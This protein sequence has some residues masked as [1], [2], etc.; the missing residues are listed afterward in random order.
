MP[1]ERTGRSAPGSAGRTPRPRAGG[2][3]TVRCL[4]PGERAGTS[5]TTLLD[6]RAGE[7]VRV[8]GISRARHGAQRRRLLDL[9]VVRGT[10]VTPELASAAG[11]PVAYRIRGARVKIVDLPGTHSLQAGSA[12]EEVAREFIPC[13]RTS[14]TCRASPSTSTRCS[15]GPGRTAGRR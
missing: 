2:A 3:A 13:W 10:P 5:R 11:D 15:A 7:T 1:G 12:N 6:A 8:T 14:A 9:G 4:P